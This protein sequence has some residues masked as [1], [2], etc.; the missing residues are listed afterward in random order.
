[1]C[2]NKNQNSGCQHDQ[3]K[4]RLLSDLE[5]I[6]VKG[7]GLLHAILTGAAAV[8]GLAYAAHDLAGKAGTAYGESVT[9]TSGGTISTPSN[10]GGYWQCSQSPCIC[11]ACG[12]SGGG[13][14]NW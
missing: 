7:A 14:V 3:D 2:Q 1:M 4:A 11:G 6:E 5:M 10:S 13:P 9:D 12:Q 8:T